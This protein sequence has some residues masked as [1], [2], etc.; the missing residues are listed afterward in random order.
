MNRA[1]IVTMFR[2]ENPEISSRV[3]SNALLHEW[4]LIGDK[5][6]CAETRCVV[7]DFTFDSLVTSS[8]YLTRY[9]LTT[10]E[11]K[12][13]DIDDYP[14]GGV[15]FDDE[16]L[17]KTSVAALDE[18][19]ENWRTRSAGTPDK[20]YTRG[21]WLYF[22]RPVETAGEEIRV[23]AVL[24]SDDFDNDNKAPYNELTYLEPFHYAVVLFL[25]KKA[26]MK[27]GKRVDELKAIREYN[28]YITWMKKMIVSKKAVSIQ[29]RPTP[30]RYQPS[31]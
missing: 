10:Q 6:I 24:V 1:E 8:V 12:F 9:D 21:K 14:G 26:K 5:E 27:V 3:I 2:T 18:E 28:A 15:S 23:Y 4:I 30:N 19:D 20:Y 7:S 31:T 25:Q 29:F 11:S 16:P 13:Y 17:E 22:D